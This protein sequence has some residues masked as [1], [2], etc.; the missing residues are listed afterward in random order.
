MPI[1][2]VNH[3]SKIYGTKQK[4]KALHDINF[5]VDKGEFV[6]IMGPSGSGKTTLLNVISSIDSISGGTV[7][8]SGNEINQ[9]SNKKLAQFR[10]KELGFIFQDYSVLPTLTVKENIMLPL[11]VQKMKKDEMEKNYQDVTEALGIYDLSDKYP[12]EISGG[13]QQRTAAARAFV[14]QPSIIFAD[15]PTGAL[16]SKSAQDLLHRLEDMN[17]QFNSTIIMV[18]HDPSAASF[19]QRVIMLKDGD[20][21]SDI[22]QQS[23]TK[24][25]FYNEIIQLQS[26]LGGVAN[27]V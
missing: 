3:V 10:K 18:T 7:E 16:D 11:S 24:S 1:L 17:K 20:I 6:A 9:L 26:A 12:S 5:S 19:A 15:E 8:I 27:D 21:H 14:H 22:H 23:K 13:Q 4:F 2:N 25:K